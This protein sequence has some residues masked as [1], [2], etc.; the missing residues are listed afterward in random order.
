MPRRAWVFCMAVQGALVALSLALLA[1]GL[2]HSSRTG[3]L[4]SGLA[5]VLLAGVNLWLMA[6]VLQPDQPS[7]GAVF[8][9][10]LVSLLL[11]LMVPFVG[12]ADVRVLVVLAVMFFAP[13]ILM[14]RTPAV[15]RWLATLG[16]GEA[17][18]S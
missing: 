17:R 8:R 7:W 11:P 16:R 2:P 12:Y 9:F 3:L 6:V 13:L 14:Q 1:S 4:A 5:L 18:V 15:V 10:H